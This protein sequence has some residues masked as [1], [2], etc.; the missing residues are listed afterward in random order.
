MLHYG[1]KPQDKEDDRVPLRSL[2]FA[3]RH[4]ADEGRDAGSANYKARLNLRAA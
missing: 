1:P 2:S 4:L 3:F